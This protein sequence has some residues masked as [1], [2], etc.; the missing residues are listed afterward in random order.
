VST[1]VHQAAKRAGGNDLVATTGVRTKRNSNDDADNAGAV[2]G[3]FAGAYWGE[4]GVPQ[5]WRDGLA[6]RDL[7]ET[8]ITLCLS[9][10]ERRNRGD[11][12]AGEG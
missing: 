1:S 8:A 12:A 5:R 2:C 3:Q 11:S 10:G 4:S 7:I 6:R 9:N